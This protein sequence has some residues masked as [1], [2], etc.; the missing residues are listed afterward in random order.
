[1][2][3]YK[4]NTNNSIVFNQE[5]FDINRNYIPDFFIAVGSLDK[6]ES[7]HIAIDLEE[8]PVLFVLYFMKLIDSVK[9]SS[10]T[11]YYK[12][13]TKELKSALKG[14]GLKY[15]NIDQFPFSLPDKQS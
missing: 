9:D 1:M 8:T 4:N 2:A 12:E 5:E 3:L 11:I 15:I 13:D 6:N 7:I 14:Y 10:I